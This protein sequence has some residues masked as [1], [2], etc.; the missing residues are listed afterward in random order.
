[1]E[2]ASLNQ[3]ASEAGLTRPLIRHHLGNREEMIAALQVY[4]LQSFGEQ[5]EALIAALPQDAEGPMII[6]LLFADTATASPDMILAFAALT[7]R[8]AED[9]E[10]RAACRDSLLSFEAVITDVL[11]RAYP[12]AGADAVNA[13][14]HGIVALYLNVASLAPLDMPQNWAQTAQAVAHHLLEGLGDPS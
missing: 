1:L 5:S 11:A 4:V 13:A 7:A 9:A 8:A 2:G 3:I 12:N 14:A 10:L 6:E